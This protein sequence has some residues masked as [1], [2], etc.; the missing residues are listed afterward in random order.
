LQAIGGS[1]G[2]LVSSW[3]AFE[4]WG[5]RGG[6]VAIKEGRCSLIR[7]TSP[8][9]KFNDAA[10]PGQ[11]NQSLIDLLFKLLGS[12]E[13]QSHANKAQ[14]LTIKPISTAANAPYQMPLQASIIPCSHGFALYSMRIK[15]VNP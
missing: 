11:A 10:L 3:Q 2:P 12:G 4:T 14:T 8:F 15:P 5:E 9:S 7:C 13:R 6:Q 1:A